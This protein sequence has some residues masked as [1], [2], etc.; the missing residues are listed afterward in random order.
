[1]KFLLTS[2]DTQ[3]LMVEEPILAILLII[4]L[5]AFVFITKTNQIPDMNT[6]KS[7]ILESIIQIELST[8]ENLG[9]E[10]INDDLDIIKESISECL[11][12]HDMDTE[13]NRNFI[14]AEISMRLNEE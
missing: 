14:L 6:E 3:K 8:I 13:E 4:T 10:S 9:L 5:I 7:D 1:M 11:K 12:E 2:M